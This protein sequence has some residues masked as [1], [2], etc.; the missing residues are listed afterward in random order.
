MQLAAEAAAAV[1]RHHQDERDQAEH[2]PQNSSTGGGAPLN[3][4]GLP[5]TAVGAREE[6]ELGAGLCVN[7]AQMENEDAGSAVYLGK[8]AVPLARAAGWDGAL[9]GF[10]GP[11]RNFRLFGDHAPSQPEG[12]GLMRVGIGLVMLEDG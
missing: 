8:D 9:S 1:P 4:A 11:A 3:C 12:R 5:G 7:G 6:A 2:G 10:E